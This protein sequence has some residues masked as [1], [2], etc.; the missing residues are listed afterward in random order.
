MA[1]VY[2]R[3]QLGEPGIRRS[4]HSW[5]NHRLNPPEDLPADGQLP[6]TRGRG[7]PRRR[8]SFTT[9]ICVAASRKKT[10]TKLWWILRSKPTKFLLLRAFLVGHRGS[11]PV[12]LCSSTIK[13]TEIDKNS[14]E[15][16]CRQI[17][18]LIFSAKFLA[19]RFYFICPCSVAFPL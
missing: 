7:K 19:T 16:V 18:S 5:G 15:S 8:F 13:L 10:T 6:R 9:H 3:I 17:A 14:K 12:V 11:H 2:G 4:Q 1:A